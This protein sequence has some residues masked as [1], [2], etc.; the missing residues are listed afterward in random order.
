M[1]SSSTKALWK[2]LLGVRAALRSKN[3]LTQQ[4]LLEMDV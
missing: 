3:A 4:T 2:Q 1:M